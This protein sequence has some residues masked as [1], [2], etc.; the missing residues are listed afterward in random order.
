MISILDIFHLAYTENLFLFVYGPYIYCI[1]QAYGVGT[2]ALEAETNFQHCLR[3]NM[4]ILV[5]GIVAFGDVF[6]VSHVG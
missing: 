5:N 3:E 2:E 4:L 1:I 6:N